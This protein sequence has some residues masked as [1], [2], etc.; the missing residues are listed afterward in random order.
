MVRA[1]EEV[2]A[3][4]ARG[5]CILVPLDLTA[6]SA[7]A[8]QEAIAIADLLKVQLTLLYVIEPAPLPVFSVGQGGTFDTLMPSLH[9]AARARLERLREDA[10]LPLQTNLAVE[11]GTPA[12]VIADYVKEHAIGLVVMATRKQRAAKRFLPDSATE[13]VVCRVACPVWILKS[14]AAETLNKRPDPFQDMSER[15]A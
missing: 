2:D 4:A 9:Q 3:Q 5:G 11:V 14:H 1:C 10:N 13:R 15:T 12:L 6:S 7:Q 8:L